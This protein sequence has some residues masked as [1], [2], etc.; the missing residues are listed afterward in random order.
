[1]A[2]EG[3][4][5]CSVLLHEDLVHNDIFVRL[6]LEWFATRGDFRFHDLVRDDQANIVYIDGDLALARGSVYSSVVEDTR[7]VV[8]LGPLAG[9]GDC[10]I[11]SI[12][13]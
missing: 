8:L 12:P 9:Y 6:R 1:M 10:T 7:V 3:I 5:A 2:G 13:C 4:Y 11:S